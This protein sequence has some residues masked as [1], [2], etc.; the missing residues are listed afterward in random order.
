MQYVA[1]NTILPCH[2]SLFTPLYIGVYYDK[3]K[4]FISRRQYPNPQTTIQ[5]L[6]LTLASLLEESCKILEGKFS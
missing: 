4:A 2:F 5:S 1:S 3:L 6:C